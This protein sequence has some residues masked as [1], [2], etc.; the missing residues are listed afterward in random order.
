MSITANSLINDSFNFFKNHLSCLFTLSLI[1]AS[2]SLILYYFL[3]P[4]DEIVTII[5][6]INSQKNLT[7]LL[8]WIKQLSEEEIALIIKVSFLSLISIFIGLILLI[9]SIITYLS[10]FSKNNEINALQSFILSLNMLPN[11]LMLLLIC[12]I[13]IYFGFMLF[14]L[15]GVI[16]AIGFSLSPIIL[17]TNKNIRILKAISQS[18]RIAFYHWWLILL[19]LL[20]LLALQILLTILLEQFYFLSNIIRNIISF[21]LNNLLISFVLIYFFRLCMLVEKSEVKK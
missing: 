4:F 15:P 20:L 12:T 2:I 1:S 7:S 14:I 18:C 5:K 21:T 8:T 13:I 9:S 11:M 3:I 6:N 16:L 10:E 19:I 17:I